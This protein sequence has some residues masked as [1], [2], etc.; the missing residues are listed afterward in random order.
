VGLG[1]GGGGG[2]RGVNH[3]LVRRFWPCA[4]TRTVTMT[5]I[6]GGA[7]PSGNQNVCRPVAS[8]RA[9]FSRS[10]ASKCATAT[11]RA[12]G[13]VDTWMPTLLPVLGCF[14]VTDAALVS[15]AGGGEVV[16]VGDGAGELGDGGVLTLAVGVDFGGPAIVPI[17]HRATRT[18]TTPMMAV[19]T[20]WRAGQLLRG[21]WGG[22]GCQDGPPG[23][24]GGCPGGFHIGWFSGT[25]IPP[26]V[27]RPSVGRALV[28]AVNRRHVAS[29]RT[30]VG[31]LH[32]EYKNRSQPRHDP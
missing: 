4:D 30:D 28:R 32:V 12:P 9:V 31:E 18:P 5:R 6:P 8:A 23:P 29:R 1:A 25:A 22:G 21:G 7:L 11:I 13:A 27:I 3:T 24:G 2:W 14:R 15:G 10:P 20:L 16:G 17:T 19:R 26:L